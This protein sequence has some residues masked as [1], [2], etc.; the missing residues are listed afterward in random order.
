MIISSDEPI[1][2]LKFSKKMVY[3]IFVKNVHHITMYNV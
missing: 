1:M 3:N 2:V